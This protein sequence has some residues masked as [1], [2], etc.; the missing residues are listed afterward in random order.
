MEYAGE[1]IS[2]FIFCY[3]F[4]NRLMTSAGKKC[5]DH[6]YYDDKNSNKERCINDGINKRDN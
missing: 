6:D 4:F 1:V 3:D 2:R 5:S